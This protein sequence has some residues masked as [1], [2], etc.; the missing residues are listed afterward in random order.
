MRGIVRQLIVAAATAATLVAFTTPAHA[1]LTVR[2]QWD[3]D[4]LPTMVD[5]AGG[6]NNGKTANITRS[7]GRY[8]FNGTDSLATV[9]DKSN[10][11]PGTKDVRLTARIS[12]TKT[13]RTGQTFDVVR[14]G[15][16][17]SEGGDYKIEI[18]RSPSGT[19]VAFCLFKDSN[20]RVGLVGGT[21]NLANKGFVTITCS[22]TSSKVTLDVDGK[23]TTIS[24]TLGSI[25]NSSPLYVGA[26]GDGTDWFPGEMAWVRVEIG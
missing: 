21:T 8:V 1:A 13:P 4:Q 25:N 20:G 26:K 15:V 5:S 22:K 2:A 3:M 10:L 6:D 24:T 19:A 7:G 17:T 18:G 9:P 11:D 23:K 14:K 12:V 16:T